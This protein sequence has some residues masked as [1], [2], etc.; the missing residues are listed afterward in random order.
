MVAFPSRYEPFGTVTIEAWAANK[1]L[2]VADAAGPVA[3][4]TNEQD[5]ILVPKDN[6]EALRDGLKRVLEDG[7][8]AHRLIEN[9]ARVYEAHFT[10]QAFVRAAMALYQQIANASAKPT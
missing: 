5:A 10:K 3:T 4:V 2:V 9:G 6:V 7:E 1:P 8:L